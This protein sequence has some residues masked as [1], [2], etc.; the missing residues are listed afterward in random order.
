MF[1]LSI[2]VHDGDGSCSSPCDQDDVLSYHATATNTSA[3]TCTLETSTTCLLERVQID[4]SGPHGDVWETYWPSCG[5]AI[6]SWSFGPGESHTEVL[7]GGILDRGIF[8]ATAYFDM[9]GLV[10][11]STTIEV[12]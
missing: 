5:E 9:P 4:V 6:S 7:E 10:Y 3:S 12:E 8:V 2:S 1:D 11:A